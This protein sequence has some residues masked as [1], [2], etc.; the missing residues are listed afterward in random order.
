MIELVDPKR[1]APGWLP[2]GER[3][4]SSSED[5]VLFHAVSDSFSE[6]ILR[7]PSAQRKPSS[8]LLRKGMI[9]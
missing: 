7:V 6:A 3:V 1:T 8:P 2:V 9:E 5:D 4:E